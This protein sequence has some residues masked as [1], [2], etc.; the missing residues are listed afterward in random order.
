MR[1]L[2]KRR[3]MAAKA[4]PVATIAKPEAAPMPLGWVTVSGEGR[5][6]RWQTAL[7]LRCNAYAMSHG[8]AANHVLMVSAAGDESATKALQAAL[9]TDTPVTFGFEF[10]GGHGRD[11]GHVRSDCGYKCHRTK[12]EN[13]SWNLLAI[14]KDPDFMPVY[15]EAAVWELLRSPKFTTPIVQAWLPYLMGEL[16]KHKARI[17]AVGCNPAVLNLTDEHLDAIVSQGLLDGAISVPGDN[18]ALPWSEPAADLDS[19]MLQNGALLGRRAERSL[20][21]LHV[22]GR[23][24]L[25]DLNLLRAPF[26]AQAHVIAATAKAWSRQKTVMIVAAIGSGKTL[27]GAGAVHLHASGQPYRALV[28]VPGHLA[29]KWQR[30]IEETIPGAAVRLFDEWSDVL[31]LDRSVKP[32]GPEWY[33]VGRDRASW[34]RPGSRHS[35]SDAACGTTASAVRPAAAG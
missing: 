6:G 20:D 27:M 11:D 4:P 17:T 29:K 10:S 15:D 8:H 5:Q 1:R 35:P 2:N 24:P 9:Q 31:R 32:K 12:L 21:P 16:E 25:P 7:R 33:I 14:V 13:G 19:Y 18:E 26:P 3:P 30:E 23:D 22:P 28:M 34:G